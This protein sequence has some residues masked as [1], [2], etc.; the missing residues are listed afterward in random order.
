MLAQ[1]EMTHCPD[2]VGTGE[3]VFPC[4]SCDGT[5]EEIC[6]QCGGTGHEYSAWEETFRSC[7]R[8]RGYGR[9]RCPSCEGH[10]HRKEMCESCVG[11]GYM[12]I[13]DAQKLA[14]ARATQE[15]ARRRLMG[16]ARSSRPPIPRGVYR[17][18]LALV[19]EGV[20]SPSRTTAN[21]TFWSLLGRFL[22]VSQFAP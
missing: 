9:L 19:P 8:C 1:A 2:C 12:P 7:P 4:I 16:G 6:Q 17:V 18:P 22:G 15:Q 5:G 13:E 3:R 20:A 11:T 14:A 10:G 21:T